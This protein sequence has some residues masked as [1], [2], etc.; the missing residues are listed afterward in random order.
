M[1]LGNGI[2]VRGGDLDGF[3]FEHCRNQRVHGAG[4]DQ[5]LVALHI[6]VD[7]GGQVRGN[8]GHAIRAGAV[9]V[10][11]Q[12]RLPAEGL[13]RL[14]DPVL[15]GCHYHARDKRGLRTRSTTCWIIGFPQSEPG[16][17]PETG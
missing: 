10:P 12:H 7:F 3:L 13:H 5:R 11:R 4:I 14:L 1:S 15:V 6:H 16:A 8:L 9:V 2:A 17:F